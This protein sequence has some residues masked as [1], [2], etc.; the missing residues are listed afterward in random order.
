MVCE[1]AVFQGT[2]FPFKERLFIV[3]KFIGGKRKVKESTVKTRRQAA[4]FFHKFV[5]KIVGAAYPRDH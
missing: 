2:S 1:K 5:I 4:P 3:R